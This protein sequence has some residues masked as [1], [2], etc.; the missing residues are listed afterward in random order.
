MAVSYTRT[1]NL[2]KLSEDGLDGDDAYRVV[3][4]PDNVPIE[5]RVIHDRR[6]GPGRTGR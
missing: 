5:P 4:W 3:M 2:D 1:V 6:G